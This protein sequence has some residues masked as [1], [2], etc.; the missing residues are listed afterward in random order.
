MVLDPRNA[1]VPLFTLNKDDIHN[2]YYFRGSAFC[3]RQNSH[4]LTA[5]HC[6]QGIPA[7]DIWIS[8]HTEHPGS[9]IRHMLEV[10][11]HPEADL[12]MLITK[13]RP[14]KRTE[15]F[16]NIKHGD[17]LGIDISAFGYPED[18]SINNSAQET[19]RLFKGHVQRSFR[20]K[21]HMGFSFV[22][23]ELSFPCP[24]GLSGGPV[25]TLR[26]NL[27]VGVVAENLE[28]STQRD[29]YEEIKENGDKTIINNMRITTYG[30]SVNLSL[31]ASWLNENCP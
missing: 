30:A 29:S 7:K 26:D 15:C 31:V 17:P 12:A 10:R 18:I 19:P 13:Y 5:A 11:F 22:A 23:N 27:L 3:Y 1:V 2:P 6:V 9:S 16:T 28:V 25:Y 21:S 24:P 8:E 20:H 4:F 14:E